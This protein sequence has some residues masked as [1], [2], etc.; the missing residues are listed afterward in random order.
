M[1]WILGIDMERVKNERI[2]TSAL[3]EPSATF[4]PSTITSKEEFG[5][6]WETL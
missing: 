3:E 5:T 6:T 2:K 4:Q 1:R